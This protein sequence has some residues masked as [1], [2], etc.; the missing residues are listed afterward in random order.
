LF[1]GGFANHRLI[2]TSNRYAPQIEV[3]F[4]IDANHILNVCASNNTTGKSNRITITNDKGRLS[5]EAIER[6]GMVQ[7]AEKYKA[8]AK[9]CCCSYQR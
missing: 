5:K 8:K 1:E 3:T 4:D 6:T 2:R 9:V 7:D